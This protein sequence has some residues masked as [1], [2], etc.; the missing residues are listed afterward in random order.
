MAAVLSLLPAVCEELMCRGLIYRGLEG[1]WGARAAVAGST[2]V[3]AL[4][5]L[6]LAQG[7]AVLVVGWYLAELRRRSGSVWAPVAAHLCNNLVA[8]GAICH[9]TADQRRQIGQPPPAAVLIG[10][11]AA[12][13]CLRAIGPAEAEAR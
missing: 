8:I 5:H 2:L 9:L 11:V 1:R 4:L 10:L 13:V 6:D 12:V 7:A 3:F